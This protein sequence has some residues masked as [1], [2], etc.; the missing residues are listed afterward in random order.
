M[1][2]LRAVLVLLHCLAIFLL[3]FPA[4][5]GVMTERNFRHPGTQATFHSYAQALQGLGLDVTKDELQAFLWDAGTRFM[6]VRNATVEPFVPYVDAVGARQGWRMFG[7]VNRAPAWL[8][9]EIQ[10]GE[11]WRRVYESRSSQH[12]WLRR[13]L[14]QERSRALV[15][16]WSWLNSRKTYEQFGV[17]LARRAAQ[18]FP[19]AEWMRT[20]MEQRR[21]PPPEKL[22]TEG[23]PAPKEHWEERYNLDKYR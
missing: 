16:S 14:D 15:N 17:W 3:S 20:R 4:P 2:H 18:D 22:R 21:L 6:A 1:K 19:Q 13:Q 8:V 5:V 12:T 10:E 9:I 7:S 23:L 11:Q